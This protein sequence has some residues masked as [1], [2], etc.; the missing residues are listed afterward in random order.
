MPLSLRY[1]REMFTLSVILQQQSI[2]KKSWM[3]SS[4]ATQ[5]YLSFAKFFLELKNILPRC[6][7]MKTCFFDGVVYI[8]KRPKKDAISCGWMTTVGDLV[9]L[10]QYILYRRWFGWLFP[11]GHWLLALLMRCPLLIWSE[12]EVLL[13]LTQTVT[14]GGVWHHLLAFFIMLQFRSSVCVLRDKRGEVRR[15]SFAGKRLLHATRY[16]ELPSV[17]S[18]LSRVNRF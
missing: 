18:D 1:W 14:E 8:P 2:H 6:F 9:I 3:R 16:V 10:V 17:I 7:W 5:H 13:G 11:V 15:W 4:S 12:C